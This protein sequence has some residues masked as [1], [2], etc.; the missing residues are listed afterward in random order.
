M[1]ETQGCSSGPGLTRRPASLATTS[2]PV[3][4]WHAGKATSTRDYVER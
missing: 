1:C 4:A 3:A 2:V